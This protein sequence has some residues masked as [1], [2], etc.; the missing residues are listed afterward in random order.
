[1]HRSGSGFSTVRRGKEESGKKVLIVAGEASGDLHGSHLVAEMLSLDPTLRFY[2]VGGEKM[3]SA[4]V[5]LL[6]DIAEMAVV[7]I[8]EVLLNINRVYKVYRRLKESLSTESPSLVILIDYPDFNLRFARAAK[9][10][11]IPIVYYISPQIWAWRK[12]R[13]LLI[14]RLIKKM[15]VI[16]PFEKKFYEDAHV[17]VDFVGHPLLDSVRPRWTR[18]Q[19]FKELS[20]TPG[21][22][23]IGI[24]PGSRMSEISR[25]LPTLL[26]ALPLIAK[27][28]GPVHFI[29][30]VAPG[31]AMSDI[32]NMVGPPHEALRVVEN[33]IYDVMQSADLLLVAS[34]TATVEATIMGTPMIVLYR[35]SPLTYF[36]GRLLIKVDHIGMV[37]IIA[38]KKVAPELSQGDF[39][40]KKLASTV[41]DM[42][43][44][45]S[46][47]QKIRQELVAVRKK[48]GDPGASAR[49][50]RIIIDDLQRNDFSK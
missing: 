5:T 7:G 10:M 2:G 32:M 36:L 23:T 37:N 4:G 8:T 27:N 31:I 17:D 47:L 25:H 46:T 21:V 12:R 49:A 30:P 6:A 26:E 48:I 19:A 35:V 13:V 28:A 22:L 18:E 20:L 33:N 14:A 40:P 24:L 15:I 38:G 34:G 42:V 45:P 41:T 11:D 43:Q 39:N 16:F 50:A 1:M 29:L 9:K 3:R 44:D